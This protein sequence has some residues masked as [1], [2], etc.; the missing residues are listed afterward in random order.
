M[1]IYVWLLSAAT[2]LATSSCRSKTA[3]PERSAAVV[4][5]A[6]TRDACSLITKEEVQAVLESPIAK[7][8]G[9]RTQ[10]YYYPAAGSAEGLGLDVSWENGE[11]VIAGAK[12]GS[13]LLNGENQ[14]VPGLG[15][16]AFFG[17]MDIALYVRKNNQA[18]TLDLRIV[19]N[20][21]AKG[22]VL[23]EKVLSRL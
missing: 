18:F 17:P 20:A 14:S 11:A 23:A 5:P 16:E 10:C 1:W 15:D 9:T 22:R 7:A 21:R 6:K 4:A 12:A 2:L 19:S 8:S 3:V 13:T